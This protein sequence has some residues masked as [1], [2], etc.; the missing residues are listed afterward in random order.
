MRRITHQRYAEVVAEGLSCY[1][2]NVR[3]LVEH[4]D[5]FV[6]DPNFA[7][8]HRCRLGVDG[9]GYEECVAHCVYAYHQLHLPASRRRTTVVLNPRGMPSVGTV[10]HEFG[11]VLH[12][13]VGWDWVARPITEYAESD[14]YEA[15]AEA[16]MGWLSWSDY[17]EPLDP[18]TFA[19]LEGLAA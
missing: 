17:G 16:C 8:L 3:R 13:V 10:V 11:H 7:D 5:V 15:F 14:R 18:A 19:L 1:P 2:D 12:E 9:I 4:A 6:G